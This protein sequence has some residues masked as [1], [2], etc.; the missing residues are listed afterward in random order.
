[1]RLIN[2]EKQMKHQDLEKKFMSWLPVWYRGWLLFCFGL[3]LI[4]AIILF[5]FVELKES[6]ENMIFTFLAGMMLGILLDHLWIQRIW[7]KKHK[8]GEIE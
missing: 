3:S 5:L 2:K 1:M 6:T 4:V 8:A 7:I